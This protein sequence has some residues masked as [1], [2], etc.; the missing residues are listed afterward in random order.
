MSVEA[1]VRRLKSVRASFYLIAMKLPYMT[2]GLEGTGGTLKAKPCHFLVEEVPLYQPCGSGNHLYINITKELMTTEELASQMANLLAISKS[3]IGFAG[4]KDKYAVTTQTFSVPAC[5]RSEAEIL[6]ALHLLNA[7]INWARLHKN[8]LKTGHLIGNRFSII[9]SSIDDVSSS[10]E[11]ANAVAESI[12]RIGLPNF[13]GEQR[14]G[15]EGNNAEKGLQVVRGNLSVRDRWLRRFLISS[16]QSELCNKYLA[17]RLNRNL[18]KIIPGDICKKHLTGGLF[19][20]E[21]PEE[22]QKRYESG[23]ISFTAPIYGTEMWHA[24]NE[25]GKLENEILESS[26]ISLEE[27]GRAGVKGTRRLGRLLVPD[28]R[29]SE[30]SEGLLVEFSLPKGAF[31]TTVLREIMKNE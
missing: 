28:I 3:E 21:N 20:S 15:V 14:F 31:A 25:S 1:K 4:M 6:S 23:E 16:L 27:L 13:F 26:G 9:I 22:E 8:K 17:E 11:K 5:N 19:A 10:F 12:R 30:I 7:K 24:S 29:I 2:S 18:F